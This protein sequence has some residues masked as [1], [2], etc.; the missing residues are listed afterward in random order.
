MTMS[1]SSW[2]TP[3]DKAYDE[4]SK[5]ISQLS[6][7]YS[8]PSFEPHVT[9]LGSIIDPETEVFEKISSIAN[10]LQPFE[11]KLTNVGYQNEFFRCL[12]IKAEES[13]ELIRS[14][15]LARKLF[16]RETDPPYMPHLSLMYGNFNP[17]IKEKI[18]TEIGK[19]FNISF[20]VENIRVVSYIPGHHD[21]SGWK[22]VKEFPLKKF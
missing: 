21:T 19:E 12:F 6:K 10:Q 9:L 2:F 5:M 14:N 7:K 18:I 11:V 20:E 3:S 1:H 13:K 16:N 8:T 22:I 17:E 4:L 15:S